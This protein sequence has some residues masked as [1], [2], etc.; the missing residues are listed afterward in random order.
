MKRLL[1]YLCGSS[2][3][4][5]QL[6]HDPPSLSLHAFADAGPLSLNAFFDSN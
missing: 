6:Y 2:S 4:G 5:I 1:H 3:D